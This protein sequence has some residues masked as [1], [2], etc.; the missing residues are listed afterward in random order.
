MKTSLGTKIVALTLG[1]LLAAFSSVAGAACYD[2]YCANTSSPVVGGWTAY[3]TYAC[4]NKV[5]DNCFSYGSLTYQDFVAFG[6]VGFPS[7]YG[8]GTTTQVP[9]CPSNTAKIEVPAGYIADNGDSYSA[10]TVSGTNY[11]S[12]YSTASV[13]VSTFVCVQTDTAN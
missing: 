7:A 10:I 5:G 3:G 13:N 8:G 11:G 9:Y 4:M 12:G 6:N 1:L 2:N